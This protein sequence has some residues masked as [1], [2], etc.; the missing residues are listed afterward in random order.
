MRPRRGSDLTKEI[1]T[2]WRGAISSVRS[3]PI[4]TFSKAGR[5]R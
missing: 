4:D 5:E 1:E 3:P 2:E